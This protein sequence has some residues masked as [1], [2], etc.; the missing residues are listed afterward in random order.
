M[1]TTI[2]NFVHNALVKLKLVSDK[3]IA[4]LPTIAGFCGKLLPIINNPTLDAIATLVAGAQLETAVQSALNLAITTFS[5]GYAIE[6]DIAA[7]PTLA[8][9]LHIFCLDLLKYDPACA[10]MKIG[11]I[12]ALAAKYLEGNGA[13]LNVATIAIEMEIKSLTQAA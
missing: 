2:K 4:Y 13:S 3:T 9:K 10:H 8:D 7:A 1:F 5:K 6:Q 12:A 11:D